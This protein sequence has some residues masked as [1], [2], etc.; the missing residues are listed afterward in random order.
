MN[1]VNALIII[2]KCPERDS[3]KTRLRG[4]ISDDER[5]RLYESLLE[6][7][8]MKLK[9]IPSVDT[10]I[11]FAPSGSEEYFSRFG[12]NLIPLPQGDLGMR[13]Y[14]A[15]QEVFQKGYGR[16]ALV[17]ADIP[18]LS[19]A[20]ITEAFQLLSHND[21]VFGPARDGGYYLIGMK[22]PVREV[23]EDVPWSS[24]QT[25]QKSLTKARING[26]S[27]AFTDTLSDIDTIEDLTMA[28]FIIPEREATE[29]MEGSDGS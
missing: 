15:F 29:R 7:T 8:V 3:V 4:L 19:G 5:L 1:N 10:S 18:D 17:G 23:F 14:H 16:A 28:G 9:S 26:H 24:D 25:L 13:M 22:R 6:Q 21:I 27:I 2:A 11:A 12:V 20:I